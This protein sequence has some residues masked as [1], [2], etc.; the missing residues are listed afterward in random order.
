MKGVKSAESTA[1]RVVLCDDDLAARAKL[2][3]LAKKHGYRVIAETGNAEDAMQLVERFGADVLVLDPNL[4]DGSGVEVARRLTGG[5][6]WN[7]QILIVGK[8]GEPALEA[9]ADL[10]VV[11]KTD[12]S[13]LNAAFAALGETA[14]EP[15]A[16]ERRQQERA[17]D[18]IGDRRSQTADDEPD[19][20]YGA[21]E[22]AEAGDSLLAVTVAPDG[23]L[24][25]TKLQPLA[26][27]A[28]TGLRMQDRLLR[29]PTSVVLLL[30]GGHPVA[31]PAVAS[32]IGDA[33]G[34]PSELRMAHAVLEDG[35]EPAELFLRVTRQL[36][37][38]LVV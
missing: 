18:N 20:F 3:K 23:N 33:W 9:L 7:G 4:R 31:G 24:D 2:A 34:D 38:A 26:V 22:L 17:H 19:D 11:H 10:P 35:D 30:V 8:P 29:L 37:E 28:L 5:G 25:P 1:L 16:I 27:V 13:G 32:R 21:L 36:R 15:E 14:T 12:R 6:T